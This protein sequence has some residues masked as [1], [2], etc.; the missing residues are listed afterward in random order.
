MNTPS[1]QPVSLL[2]RGL[3]VGAC[4]LTLATGCTASNVT[5][6]APAEVLAATDTSPTFV[7]T[8]SEWVDAQIACVERHGVAAER[9]PEN[10][11]PSYAVSSQGVGEERSAEVMEICRQEIGELN[12]AGW[13]D[14]ALTEYYEQSLSLYR[15]LVDAGYSMPPMPSLESFL[16]DVE[17]QGFSEFDAIGLAANAGTGASLTDV[18]ADCPRPTE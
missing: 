13:D 9:G 7:G 10:D 2:L 5:H 3:A 12:V 16:D 18:L 4:A 1:H 8:N 11:N 14:E 6:D 15:C 17:R